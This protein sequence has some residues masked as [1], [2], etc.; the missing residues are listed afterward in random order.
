MKIKTYIV[1]YKEENILKD[2]LDSFIETGGLDLCDEVNI[3][4]NFGELKLDKKYDKFTILNNVTRPDFSRGHLSRNWNQGLIN[5]FRDLDNPDADIV[6]LM[7]NDLKFFDGWTDKLLK[8]HE[9]FDFI[10]TG[11]GDGFM[12]FTPHAVKTIGIFDERYCGTQF[13]ESDYFVR[14]VYHMPDTVSINDE[15]EGHGMRHFNSIVRR[16]PNESGEDYFE[17]IGL[18]VKC[19]YGHNQEEGSVYKSNDWVAT[20]PSHSVIQTKFSGLSWTNL[21][22]VYDRGKAGG[23]IYNDKFPMTMIYPYFENKIPD[24]GSKGYLC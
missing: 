3:I 9:K 19:P 21:Q 12:S 20:S 1:T 7:Q 10:S 17:R 13:Q 18:C 22:R 5:G 16:D 8:Y 4:N 2:T 11:M 14:G 15:I 24:R 23:S 6:I